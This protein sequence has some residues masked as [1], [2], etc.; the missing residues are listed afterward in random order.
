MIKFL[1][2]KKINDSFQPA[3]NEAIIRAADSGRY[4]FGKEVES[5]EKEYAAYIGSDHAVAC[6]SGL[7]A[8]TL[9]FKAYMALGVMSPGDEVIL[10]AN[11]F[12]ASFLAVS[13]AGLVPIGVDADPDTLQI[14][15]DHIESA[16][17]PK[18][19]AIMIV[20]LYGR[21]AYTPGIEEIC[22]RHGLKLIEDNAQ[23]A[24]CLT[25][26]GRHTGSLG[27]AA[28]HSFYPGKNLGALG[29]GGCVTTSD[30]LLADMIRTLAFYGSSKR[31]VFDHIGRN[32]RL[33]EIQAAALRV[34]LP[35]L[36]NDNDVRRK[37]AARYRDEIHNPLVTVPMSD[38][39]SDSPQHIYHLFPVLSE[40]RD[41]LQIFLADKGIETLIHY[42]IPPHLQ[43]CYEGRLEVRTP[44]PVTEKIH[45]CELSLPISPV[46]S[47]EEVGW[48]IEAVNNFEIT[49]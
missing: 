37:I 25:L 28:G 47:D 44:L 41:A 9:I 34:K 15:P 17:T 10:P 20:H 14:C 5:F 49:T 27:H 7:D 38:L 8:L 19:R 18:T 45:A 12:I 16:I 1:D 4:L 48:V 30:P 29:D 6:A 2:L 24:G 26:D 13:E 43:K 42:P 46:M 21:N 11:T 40:H 22:R 39:A 35:R 36:D 23:A 33:D 32:S 3:L 31:Y